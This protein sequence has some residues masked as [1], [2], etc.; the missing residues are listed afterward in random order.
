M[1]RVILH[2]DRLVL[3]GFRHED[4]HTVGEALHEE[5]VRQFSTPDAPQHLASRDDLSRLKVGGVHMASSNK[6]SQVGTQTAQGIARE[7]KS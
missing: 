4:R 2:I 7:V 1:K 6:P 5:L 3:R